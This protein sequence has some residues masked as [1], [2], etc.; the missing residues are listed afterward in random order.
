MIASG[1]SRSRAA[2]QYFVALLLLMPL[3]SWGVSNGGDPFC[4]WG[5]WRC[6]MA[7]T[8]AQA[9]A[10]TGS[11]SGMMHMA[12][13]AMA[14]MA[15]CQPQPRCA[16]SSA[17]HV[18]LPAPAAPVV[19]GGTVARLAPPVAHHWNGTEISPAPLAA[20]L[21]PIFHPPLG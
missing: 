17:P 10:G 11:R 7:R 9:A 8:G 13:G 18:I 2:R 19:P 14:H 3:L 1:S 12:G 4:C 21:R 6:P 20:H 5:L 15:G 16:M